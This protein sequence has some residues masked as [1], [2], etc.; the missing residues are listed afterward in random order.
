MPDRTRHLSYVFS[1]KVI[2]M[3]T[4]C[5]L[6][7]WI[8]ISGW[9]V[10]YL[11]QN[12]AFDEVDSYIKTEDC[13]VRAFLQAQD[14]AVSY[15]ENSSE[16]FMNR[17]Y[18]RRVTNLS[19][20]IYDIEAQETVYSNGEPESIAMESVLFYYPDGYVDSEG[21]TYFGYDSTANENRQIQAK[22]RVNY[23]LPE[24]LQVRDTYFYG[25][26]L[27]SVLYGRRFF[28]G[29][30]LIVA[31]VLF[32]VN[33]V[34]LMSGAGHEEGKEGIILNPIDRIPF[35]LL[36]VISAGLIFLILTAMEQS[37]VI[38]AG[39]FFTGN[40]TEMGYSVSNLLG[41]LLTLLMGLVPAGY[42]VL[43][44][45]LTLAT[46]VKAGRWYE[47]TLI[48][49]AGKELIRLLV[50]VP[51]VPGAAAFAIC[52]WILIF[53]L[54]ARQ[55]YEYLIVLAALLSALTIHRAWQ[56]RRLRIISRELAE[57]NLEC[58]ISEKG[59]TG[60]Y[61]RQAE[62]LRNLRSAVSIAVEK[63]MRAEHLQT[64]LITN[65]SHD[66]KTPLTSIVN[67]V[68]LLGKEH[69]EEQEKQ[70]LEALA[71]NSARL[72]RLTEDLVEASKASTGSIA[73]TFARTNLRE[74]LE[75][76]LAEYKDRMDQAGLR[77]VLTLE[78]D[79][80]C[81]RADGRLLWRVLSNLFSNCVKYSLPSTRV[82]IDACR[83]PEGTVH[84]TVKN[85]SRD[86]LNV[87]PDELMERFVRGDRARN[88]EGSGLGLNIAR[89][90]TELQNGSLYLEVDGDLFKATV[91]MQEDTSEG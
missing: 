7:V 63:E 17:Y 85:T 12:R 30:S 24:V 77:P 39:V 2:A 47:N 66:I 70:Y 88:T 33:A 76:A 13:S 89:S 27:Y 91:V 52:G 35:D 46:R 79:G 59:L 50:L 31:V 74:M 15:S 84:I 8:L 72:K 18:G 25:E 71:R 53:F 20:S 73:V 37:A 58:E 23:S 40:I 19:L 44:W 29:I 56:Q 6:A 22:Y 3:I 41:T 9:A 4:I 60:D 57:G 32:A 55:R 34:F 78:D 75:Q 45:I 62:D 86:E 21:G 87:S 28:F 51:S 48:W 43:S 64:E 36:T 1:Y 68:S 11:L 82:Y 54:V 16:T 26:R 69:T 49:M 61:R 14:A 42:I 80:L 5:F 38:P 83:G 65:V 90:L 81:V 67:Y 10:T